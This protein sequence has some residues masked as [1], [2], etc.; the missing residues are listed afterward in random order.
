MVSLSLGKIVA[1]SGSISFG[2]VLDLGKDTNHAYDIRG[3]FTVAPIGIAVGAITG[4]EV[5][6]G[7]VLGI[8]PLKTRDA[9]GPQVGAAVSFA[10]PK[11]IG[12]MFGVD[13]SLGGT[14]S[15]LPTFSI[16]VGAGNPGVEVGVTGGYAFTF[17]KDAICAGFGEA[18]ACK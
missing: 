1:Y 9:A 7:L 2:K 4:A 11:I 15:P 12:G 18:D 14:M 13:W 6:G 17:N 10:T 5:W 8:S 16:G 3:I